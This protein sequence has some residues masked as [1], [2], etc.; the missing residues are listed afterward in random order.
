MKKISSKVFLVHSTLIGLVMITGLVHARALESNIEDGLYLRPDISPYISYL[1]DEL[2]DSEIVLS[3]TSYDKEIGSTSIDQEDTSNS[4]V[5]QSQFLAFLGRGFSNTSQP[6]QKSDDLRDLFTTLTKKLA[7]QK[8]DQ[9]AVVSDTAIK[10]NSATSITLSW[11]LDKFADVSIHYS[12]S[13]DIFASNES[14][15]VKISAFK[16][17][18]QAT[19]DGLVPDTTYNYLI[20]SHYKNKQSD[21]LRGTW[22]TA[23]Q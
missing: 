17:M 22:R 21:I 5:Q 6:K 7:V 23:P 8:N 4:T 1:S 9:R 18:N 20:V 13:S 14:K 10:T 11:E 2:N 12:T 3:Q 16:F 15:H 19:I